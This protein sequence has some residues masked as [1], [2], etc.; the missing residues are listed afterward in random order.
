M[1]SPSYRQPATACDARHRSLVAQPR[2]QHCRRRHDQCAPIKLNLLLYLTLSATTGSSFNLVYEGQTF[3]GGIVVLAVVIGASVNRAVKRPLGRNDPSTV[4][5]TGKKTP[6]MSQMRLADLEA[7]SMQRSDVHISS[8]SLAQALHSICEG[9][10]VGALFCHN[11]RQ[12]DFYFSY[13][14]THVI[15]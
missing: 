11:F 1:P 7:Q 8:Q 12:G 10:G 4:D 13:T 6:P 2:Q 3:G 9:C 14:C 5:S 15:D